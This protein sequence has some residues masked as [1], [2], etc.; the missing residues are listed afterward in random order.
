[1]HVISMM[2]L[3]RF[4]EVHP[5][6]EKPLR[7]WFTLASDARWRSIADVRKDYPHADAV[8]VASGNTATI[9]NVA[10]NKYRLI[11]CIHYN[12]RKVYVLRVFT[13]TEYDRENWK[14]QL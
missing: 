1:M 14:E 10:G 5:E 7:G 8:P 9:F 3:R 11:T 2:A 12:R 6:A 13:H 4:W